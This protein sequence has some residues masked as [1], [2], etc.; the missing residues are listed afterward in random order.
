MPHPIPLICGLAGPSLAP[1][2][3]AFFTAAQPFGFILMGRNCQTPAQLQALVRSLRACLRHPDAPVLIDQEGG[4]VAR[5]KPPHWPSFPP[6]AVIGALHAQS[7]ADGLELARLTGSLIGHALHALGINVNCAPVLDIAHP[8]THAAIGD[9]AFSADPAAVAALAQA[10]AE[11]LLAQGVLPVIKHLPGH[12]RAALDPHIE[13]PIVACDRAVVA[14]DFLPFRKLAAMPLGMTSH[15]LFKALDPENPSSQSPVIIRDIIRRAIGF[16]GLL[17][18]DDLDMKAL[19][20]T[21]AHRA[22]KTLA[23]GT[24]ILLVCNAPVAA[25][26]TLS[27]LPPMAETAWR[28]WQRAQTFLHPPAA[29][30]DHAARQ[31]RY[32]SLLAAARTV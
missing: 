24:D 32:A 3:T 15:I 31:A 6:A 28:R 14:A 19:G 25:L 21:L 17:I 16:N 5:L 1:E 4:S 30:P 22:E 2:E 7:P 27:T 10:C 26:Q 9:R 13:L 8:E 20:G 29:M 12:G 23:A 11:G 18:S